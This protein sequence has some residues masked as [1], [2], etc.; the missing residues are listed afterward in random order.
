MARTATDIQNEINLVD[1]AISSAL[2]A[3]LSYSRPGFARTHMSLSELRTHRQ[4]LE[5]ELR[6][7]DGGVGAGLVS[8]FANTNG[9][10]GDCSDW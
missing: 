3:G 9:T 7:L 5:N 2:K 1:A 4:S 8:D 10:D 6:K